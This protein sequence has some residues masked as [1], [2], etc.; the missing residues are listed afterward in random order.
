MDTNI[1]AVII[2]SFWSTQLIIKVIHLIGITTVWY[3]K[4]TTLCLQVV[5]AFYNIFNSVPVIGFNI[6]YCK[7]GS[8]KAFRESAHKHGLTEAQAEGMYKDGDALAKEY[9]S[10]MEASVTTS[11]TTVA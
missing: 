3:F 4:I 11:S 2:W 7:E 6:A 9:R 5:V 8:Y 10:G 1:K